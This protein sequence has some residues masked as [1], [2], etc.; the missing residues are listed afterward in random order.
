MLPG[1]PNLRLRGIKHLSRD[2]DVAFGSQFSSFLYR[3]VD[4]WQVL[5]P[6]GTQYFL[7]GGSNGVG[8]GPSWSLLDAYGADGSVQYNN[9]G[10]LNGAANAR[11]DDSTGFS[12]VMEGG[13]GIYARVGGSHSHLSR[14]GTG[15]RFTVNS[16]TP[17][18]ILNENIQ[19]NNLIQEGAAFKAWYAGYCRDQSGGDTSQI[20]VYIGASGLEFLIYDT[21]VFNSPTV[22]TSCDVN[23]G[24]NGG[25]TGAGWRLDIDAYLYDA[26]NQFFMT[27]VKFSIEDPSLSAVVPATQ[28]FQTGFQ[29][30]YG[31]AGDL[32]IRIVATDSRAGGTSCW[33]GKNCFTQPGTY[34]V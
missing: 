4:E 28:M 33:M 21:G 10:S 23:G 2:L 27:S 25:A 30:I 17:D 22:G 14:S 19:Y 7:R 8:P 29:A 5:T 13:S 11:Y 12:E 32:F 31:G 20:Q 24:I 18:D 9:G 26:G 6:L 16:G 15:V 1:G 3:G 34:T